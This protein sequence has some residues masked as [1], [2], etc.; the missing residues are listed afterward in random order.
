MQ[1]EQLA[2][3]IKRKENG[4]Y[5]SLNQT[6]ISYPEEGNQN[7][8]ELEDDSYWFKH[9]NEVIAGSIKKFSPT[10]SFFDIGGGNG[11]VAL[12]LQKEG[13]DVC[14]IEPGE[15]GALTAKKRGINKVICSTLE[16]A[17]F[18]DSSLDS[19]GFFDVME[20]IQDDDS[21]LA[22]VTRFLK[23]NGYLYLTVPAFQFL[24][25]DVDN[26]SGHYKRYT[27]DQLKRMLEKHGYE[28]KYATY[29]FAF[30]TIPIFLLR[31]IPA[32]FGFQK[33]PSS[34]E[35][36]KNDHKKEDGFI[37]R[38]MQKSFRWEMKQVLNQK[39]LFTG[40]SCF[41]IARKK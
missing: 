32:K 40:S 15:H 29:F 23:P 21:F 30:L 1:L 12:R 28:V 39:K 24:W 34:V 33:D 16:N 13:I 41:V 14:L 19:V 6:D 9:R 18:E 38:L 3:N 11:F 26:Y 4:I 37:T 7:A 8:S 22:S 20:H 35:K 10:Q 25:S 27:T 5:Y 31:T 2:K 17:Q 36:Q